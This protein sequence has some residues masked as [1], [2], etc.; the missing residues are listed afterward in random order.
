MTKHEIFAS[1]VNSLSLIEQSMRV[2][3]ELFTKFFEELRTAE[4]PVTFLD[5][6][7]P[8]LTEILTLDPETIDAAI[9][10]VKKINS[11]INIYGVTRSGDIKYSGVTLCMLVVGLVTP[12]AHPDVAD[13]FETLDGKMVTQADPRVRMGSWLLRRWR[14]AE[15]N[16][17]FIDPVTFLNWLVEDLDFDTNYMRL[18]MELIGCGGGL[19]FGPMPLTR[20][21]VFSA[22]IRS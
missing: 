10:Q 6:R 18:I 12:E 14:D 3:T 15:D 13:E 17:G 9:A 8:A 21:E 19:P 4:K 5:S 20:M 7:I 11:I 22:G 1:H 2:K 16:Q